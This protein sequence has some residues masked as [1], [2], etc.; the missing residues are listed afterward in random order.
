MS[1]ILDALKKSESERQQQTTNEFSGVP[2]RPGPD[3][4]PRW[5][6]IVGILL[7]INLAVLIGLLLRPEPAAT[8]VLVDAAPESIA[9]PEK[10]EPSF[11]D[12][13]AA[14][15]RNPPP[16]Q[17]DDEP[18]AEA[19][20]AT[21]QVQPVVISQDRE[22]IRSTAIYPS[23]QEVL[24][25]GAVSLPEL[26]VDIHVFSETPSDRFVFINMNKYREGGLL[27]EGPEVVEITTDGVVLRYQGSSFLLT[28]D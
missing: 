20:P 7:A 2:T 4:I 8:P 22:A 5:L 14:A 1:F 18:E 21:Q 6:W 12:Q 16:G 9:L 13:V 17:P 26:H 25:G 24:A 27:S 28:R 11:T 15:Q 10:V 19:T 3:R 23:M